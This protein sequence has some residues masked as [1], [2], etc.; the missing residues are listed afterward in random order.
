M[1]HGKLGI[2]ELHTGRRV[3]VLIGAAIFNDVQVTRKAEP[4]RHWAGSEA[5]LGYPETTEDIT[6]VEPTARINLGGFERDVRASEMGKDI[7]IFRSEIPAETWVDR[8]GWDVQLNPQDKIVDISGASGIIGECGSRM[9]MAGR[10]PLAILEERVVTEREDVKRLSVLGGVDESLV[11]R[12]LKNLLTEALVLNN[13]LAL[14][15]TYDREEDKIDITLLHGVA[16]DSVIFE[17]LVKKM[18]H[19]ICTGFLDT[20]SVQSHNKNGS[21]SLLVE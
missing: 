17:D 16:E 8:F 18:L 2:K 4:K 7:L 11:K 10:T 1:K 6:I 13:L 15:F 9:Q 21:L 20:M 5:I 14:N 19:T 3:S 12:Y